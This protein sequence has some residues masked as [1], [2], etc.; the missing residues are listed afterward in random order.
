M[1]TSLVIFSL[2][3]CAA[4]SSAQDN[5]NIPQ[6]PFR[7]F[8][9]T[10]YVGT[11]G[12]SAILITSD[13]GHILVDGALPQSA[14]LIEAN[15]SRLGFRIRDVRLIVNSHEHFDHAGGLGALQRASGARVAA[16][17]AAARA[18]RQG[19]PTPEDP[20][21]RS[22][23][24]ARY[25]T[26]EKVETIADGDTLRV[27][28]LGITAH[29]TPGHT[30]GATTWSWRSCADGRCVD[31]V[32]ADSM[33]PVSDDGFRFT[34]DGTRPSLVEGFRRSFARVEKLPCDILLAPH[35][36]FFALPDKLVR[37]KEKPDLNPFID[38]A[39]CRTFATFA[40]K[41]LE[42]R[43]ATEQK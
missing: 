16:S 27:G 30:P 18:L 31:I 3:V 4:V 29:F 11:A 1:R 7:I 23:L 9:N 34:G 28:P 32:Y 39:A 17:P 5:W 35:P 2:V 15:I 12:L 8:G 10:F 36:E 40:R 38:A 21:H 33:S 25:P 13:D 22:G 26:V 20:Q 42:Q 43:I 37:L 41:R 6:A 14:P 24:E 19:Y